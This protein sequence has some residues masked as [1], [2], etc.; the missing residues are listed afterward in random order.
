MR[1]ALR[2]VF[3]N[4]SPKQDEDPQTGQRSHGSQLL[5][6][7]TLFLALT[8]FSHSRAA[9]TSGL[10]PRSSSQGWYRGRLMRLITSATCSTTTNRDRGTSQCASKLPL[11]SCTGDAM[12][13]RSRLSHNMSS[14]CPA[15]H[16][17][18]TL[19]HHRVSS[20][21]CLRPN[22]NHARPGVGSWLSSL[23]RLPPYP[24]PGLLSRGEGERAGQA[25]IRYG[26]VFPR[27]RVWDLRDEW[28]DGARDVDVQS[29][30]RQ[31]SD[32]RLLAGHVRQTCRGFPCPSLSKNLCSARKAWADQQ[33]REEF[34][35]MAMGIYL[36]RYLT[37][38]DRSLVPIAI[39]TMQVVHKATSR[40]MQ[41]AK[42]RI[43]HI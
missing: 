30:N 40:I 31:A 36:G 25:S 11:S 14:F 35:L 33:G 43:R 2:R 22:R 10:Q 38:Y 8:K 20:T 39:R 9:S 3:Y 32:S 15:K 5:S 13:C 42:W 26:D 1:R 17:D 41:L 29:R 23:W 7:L 12:L 6:P 4:V 37:Y 27:E 34:Q 28:G 16:A 21:S 18:P 19:Q 24:L